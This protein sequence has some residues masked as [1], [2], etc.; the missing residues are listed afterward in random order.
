MTRDE[1]NRRLSEGQRL[2]WNRRRQIEN[3][4]I[5]IHTMAV[6]CN[7]TDIDPYQIAV[8]MGEIEKLAAR[9]L[10]LH[11]AGETQ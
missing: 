9:A 6:A 8:Q 4:L 1:H 11:P 2:A 3:T 10:F 5:A 7:A